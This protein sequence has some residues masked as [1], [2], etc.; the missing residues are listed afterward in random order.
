MVTVIIFKILIY[1][2]QLLKSIEYK[3]LKLENGE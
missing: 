2:D 1:N 3:I